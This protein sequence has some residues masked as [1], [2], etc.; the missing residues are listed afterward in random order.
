[1]QQIELCYISLNLLLKEVFN[2][3]WTFLHPYE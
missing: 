1:M 3:Q 2:T